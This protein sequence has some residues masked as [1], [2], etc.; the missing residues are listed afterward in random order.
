MSPGSYGP[1]I[2]QTSSLPE[3]AAFKCYRI[4]TAP[5][6]GYYQIL[7]ISYYGGDANEYFTVGLFPPT[8]NAEGDGPSSING[9][10]YFAYFAKVKGAIHN[11]ENKQGSMYQGYNLGQSEAAPGF[12]RV[13]PPG[14]TLWIW[15]IDGTTNSEV[16]THTLAA[17]CARLD[18]A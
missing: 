4:F 12:M 1:P 7:D 18:Y 5:D 9:G 13:V 17:R 6:D 16:I 15:A 2:M 8:T 14:W 3:V 11:T 10:N